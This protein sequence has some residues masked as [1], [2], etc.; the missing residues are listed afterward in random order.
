MEYLLYRSPA[1]ERADIY[2]LPVGIIIVFGYYHNSVLVRFAIH[3]CIANTF[4]DLYC[5]PIF[6]H[7]FCSPLMHSVAGL[8]LLLTIIQI[9][10]FIFQLLY[11]NQH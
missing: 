9:C 2:A 5:Y 3:T 10:S 11:F 7:L 6:W 1:A 4:A 8:L